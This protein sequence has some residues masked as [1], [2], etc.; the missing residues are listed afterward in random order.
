MRKCTERNK[1]DA[2]LI[3]RFVAY[4]CNQYVAEKK[5]TCNTLDNGEKNTKEITYSR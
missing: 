3:R 1:C 5:K 4:A 2:K